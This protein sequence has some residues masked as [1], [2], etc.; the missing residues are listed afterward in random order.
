MRGCVS[1]SVSAGEPG[2]VKR[3]RSIRP[4]G[5]GL[6]DILQSELAVTLHW[7]MTSEH[8]T[9]AR[10][11]RPT[12]SARDHARE[13]VRACWP[14]ILSGLQTH[15]SVY[16]SGYSPWQTEEWVPGRYRIREITAESW[17]GTRTHLW[18]MG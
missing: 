2:S 18:R 6:K 8:S 4:C 1:V 7:T 17:T 16:W 12:E 10:A 11:L 15:F 9:S 3:W 14:P 5:W 13:T